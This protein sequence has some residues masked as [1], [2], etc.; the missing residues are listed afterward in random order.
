MAILLCVGS[1]FATFSFEAVGKYRFYQNE[2]KIN[3]LFSYAK[4]MSFIQKSDVFI[5]FEQKKGDL[6]VEVD[7]EKKS[8]KNL[9]LLFNNKHIQKLEIL[10]SSSGAILPEGKLAIT[11]DKNLVELKE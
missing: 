3:S 2:Q 11:D 5:T 10:I 7:S 8:L 9:K 6:F 4:K 1:F